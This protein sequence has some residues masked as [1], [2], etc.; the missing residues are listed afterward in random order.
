ME[1]APLLLF[2]DTIRNLYE[3]YEASTINKKENRRDRWTL[4][5]ENWEPRI[6][7]QIFLDLKNQ[8]SF[9]YVSCLESSGAIK[10]SDNSEV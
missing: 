8:M 2:T 9:F 1:N 3:I 7:L 6:G 10:G 5:L 4:F